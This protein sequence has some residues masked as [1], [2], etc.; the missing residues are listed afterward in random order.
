MGVFKELF[1]NHLQQS[2]TNRTVC[3]YLLF[4]VVAVHYV[5]NAELNNDL[6]QQFHPLH[7]HDALGSAKLLT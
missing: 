1:L 3:D 2:H 6:L 7:C 5:S 4:A